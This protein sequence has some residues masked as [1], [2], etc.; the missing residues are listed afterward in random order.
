MTGEPP[1]EHLAAARRIIAET[2]DRFDVPES[3]ALEWLAA[4]VSR[5]IIDSHVRPVEP[6]AA[7]RYV[8]VSLV[9]GDTMFTLEGRPPV[10]GQGPTPKLFAL[11]PDSC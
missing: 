5:Q 3:V 11:E 2:A 4:R 9:V 8:S 7:C 6:D 10:R 1:A